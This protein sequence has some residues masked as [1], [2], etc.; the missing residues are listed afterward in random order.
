MSEWF[1]QMLGVVA[2]TL[3]I[4]AVPDAAALGLAI[5]LVALAT[6]TIVVALSL[7]PPSA[8]SAPHPLRAI[9]VSALLAQS[10][11]DAAGHPRPRAPGVAAA[12]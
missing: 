12:V 9:D 4:V 7:A 3:G 6:L 8:S 5:A 11:P 2:A 10:D 1:G